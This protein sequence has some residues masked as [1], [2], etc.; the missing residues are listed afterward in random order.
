LLEQKVTEQDGIIESMRLVM[1]VAAAEHGTLLNKMNK[2]L[3]QHAVDK[4]DAV[5]DATKARGDLVYVKNKTSTRIKHL[6]R[7]VLIKAKDKVEMQSILDAQLCGMEESE[8]DL[9]KQRRILAVKL[10]DLRK[11]QDLSQSQVSSLAFERAN[12]K[13]ERKK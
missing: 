7:D 1:E 3:G 13:T 6:E 8:R 11:Q 9:A 2:E 12:I 10:E 4:H 5:E